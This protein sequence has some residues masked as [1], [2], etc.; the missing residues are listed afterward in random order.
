MK[1]TVGE[2]KK[3]LERCEDDF[4]IE[5]V[6]KKYKSDRPSYYKSDVEFGDIGYSDRVFVLSAEIEYWW[7]SA[8][9][10]KI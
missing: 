10:I 7:K 9:I 3:L 8:F 2:L 6:I 1:F 4:A 5:I